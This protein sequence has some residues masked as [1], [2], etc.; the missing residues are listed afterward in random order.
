M[1]YESGRLVALL[2]AAIDS[3]ASGRRVLKSPAGASIGGFVVS[4]A[5]KV[6]AMLKI[7]EEIQRYASANGLAGIELRI[8][9]NAYLRQPND[10]QS[11]SL[12]VR[13]FQLAHRWFLFMV[14]L[15]GPRET[16]L[17]RVLSKS[18]RYD[19]R[20]NL[21]KGLQPGEASPDKLGDFYRLL[22]ETFG[23]QQAS[24]THTQSELADL[25]V[26]VP[27]RVRLF[28]CTYQ[29][30]AIA[31]VAAFMLNDV[32]ANTFYICESEA[33]RKLCGPAV[34]VAHV[35]EQMAAE[36]FRYLDLG[37]S[38]SDTHFNDGLVFFKEG[39]GAQ[40]FCRETWRWER[41]EV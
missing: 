27:G 28:L 41:P 19:V 18:K 7:V 39:F 14:P 25:L 12:M 21:K 8:G 37:P 32:I 6:G 36:G 4:P 11:F 13:G 15:S 17:E 3:E 34:L 1:I 2:P 31:G 35:A 9:P 10:L 20:A 29:G 22:S 16:L 40:G 5:L 23:R 33:H 26:R 38:A 30:A 24:P